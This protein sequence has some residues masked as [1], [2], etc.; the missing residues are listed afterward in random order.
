M[1]IRNNN[2]SFILFLTYLWWWKG[3]AGV[4]LPNRK[5]VILEGVAIDVGFFLFVNERDWRIWHRVSFGLWPSNL[6][7]ACG[8][9]SCNQEY[10]AKLI[11]PEDDCLDFTTDS[12]WRLSLKSGSRV[13]EGVAFEPV[14]IGESDLGKIHHQLHFIQVCATIA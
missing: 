11:L 14:H 9:F 1:N 13:E 8:W 6:R 7:T 2:Q 3:R 5:T 10:F 12:E 4:I